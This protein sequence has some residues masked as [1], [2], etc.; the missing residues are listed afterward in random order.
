[1][2][3]F[4][5]DELIRKI[6]TESRSI[7][8]IGASPNPARPSHYVSRMLMDRGYR[9]V[10][11]NPGQAGKE[12]LETTC[13]GQIADID[14]PIDMVDIF[15]RSDA[16]PAIVEAALAHLPG[17]KTIWMQL[18]VENEEAAKMAE[19]AGVQ[20]IQNRC[21]KAEYQRLFGE[22]KLDEISA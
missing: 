9:I 5:T 14:E 7:A 15:R 3:K 21:T 18:G 19:A 6:L 10:P 4:P 8:V 20:V 2:T 22:T 12:L 17:L 1:M 16:V 11:V 13:M